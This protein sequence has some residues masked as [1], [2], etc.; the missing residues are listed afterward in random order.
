MEHCLASR[1]SHCPDEDDIQ[2]GRKSSTDHCNSSGQLL[3]SV[4]Q[5]K[6]Y[7]FSFQET[8]KL[9][10][11]RDLEWHSRSGENFTLFDKLILRLLH[12]VFLSGVLIDVMGVTNK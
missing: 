2:A 3:F 10:E 12:T 11:N 6:R 5:L 7:F 1:Q 8:L 9:F 4:D